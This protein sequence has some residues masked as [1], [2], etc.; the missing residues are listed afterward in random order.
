MD[1]KIYPRTSIYAE[2]TEFEIN[3]FYEDEM[4]AT[5]KELVRIL[6]RYLQAPFQED[7]LIQSCKRGVACASLRIWSVEELRKQTPQ[8]IMDRAMQYYVANASDRVAI[9]ELS[10]AIDDQLAILAIYMQEPDAFREEYVAARTKYTG[11]CPKCGKEQLLSGF[12][13][14]YMFWKSVR[15]ERYVNHCLSCGESWE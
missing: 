8:Q 4:G 14:E 5:D 11:K 9:T 15:E 6:Q 1:E 10:D 2:P 13:S 7:V 3:G 12:R